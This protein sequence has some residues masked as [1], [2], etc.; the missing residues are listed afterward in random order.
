MTAARP[1][2]HL[3][4]VLVGGLLVLGVVASGLAI[5]PGTLAAQSVA[6]ILVHPREHDPVVA[7]SARFPFGAQDDP[8]EANG[9]AFLLGRVI[10][11]EGSVRLAGMSARIS[12]DVGR[13]EFLVTMV[14][15]ADDWQAA[16]GEVRGLL[17]GGPLPE[18]AVVS[19]RDR[20]RERLLF[21][22]GAPGRTFD[23][24]KLRFLF[25]SG[26]AAARPV[27]GTRAG[28]EALSRSVLESVRSRL[29]QWEE[30]VVGIVGPVSMES[31]AGT[32]SGPSERVGPPPPL[33]PP[34]PA[35]PADTLIDPEQVRPTPAPP[36]GPLVRMEE[37]SAP[38][39]VPEATPGSAPWSSGDRRVID[40][41]VTSSW[42]MVAWPLPSGAHMILEDFLV[43]LVEQQMNPSPPDPGVYRA[44]AEIQRIGDGPVLVVTASVDPRETYRWEER[45]LGTLDAL[46]STPPEGAFFEL[47]RRQYRA[48]RL[49]SHAVPEERSRWMTR[50]HAEGGHVPRIP[51]DVWGLT[52]EGVAGLASARGEPRI[53]LFG[54]VGVMDR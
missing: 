28:L 14:A 27:A 32:F 21:E 18:G 33:A 38:F 5:A 20:H 52:R 15:P 8:G 6:Q 13:S 11:E 30:A 39:E 47:S 7:V 19:A 29:V 24:E 45:I 23:L 54:P 22:E 42:I 9:A 37:R 3:S 25:G 40:Q 48:H 51:A 17:D 50:R 35:A 12:V 10:E 2:N 36:S 4:R 31:T 53:L 26:H 43:H 44:E 34:A 46:A 49:L 41:D 1:S 16:W